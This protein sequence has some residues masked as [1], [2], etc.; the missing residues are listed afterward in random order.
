MNTL[1]STIRLP[2]VEVESFSTN[3]PL[4][5]A[6][7]PEQVRIS[8]C[9]ES[10]PN[11]PTVCVKDEHCRLIILVFILPFNWPLNVTELAV[12]VDVPNGVHESVP[13]SVKTPRETALANVDTVRVAP[14]GTVLAAKA[15]AGQNI[16]IMPSIIFHESPTSFPGV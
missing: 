15:F 5:I 2:A 3:V 4:P 14:E 1:K 10:N 11:V 7:A 8:P 12:S 13:P 9:V 16:E 6:H